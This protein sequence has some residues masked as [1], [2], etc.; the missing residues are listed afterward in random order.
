[1]SLSPLGNNCL[2]GKSKN[3]INFGTQVQTKNVNVAQRLK[4]HKTLD[5]GE[6]DGLAVEK[7]TD[8]G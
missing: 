2:L 6:E 1:M 3:A 5:C 7:E 8:P 4:I